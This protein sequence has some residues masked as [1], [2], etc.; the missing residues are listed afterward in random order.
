M[1]LSELDTTS[2]TMGSGERKKLRPFLSGP[3]QAGNLA[4]YRRAASTK[5]AHSLTGLTLQPVMKKATVEDN[6]DAVLYLAAA[7][8]VSGEILHADAAAPTRRWKPQD[9]LILSALKHLASCQ[10]EGS[11]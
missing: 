11:R 9:N 1:S 8:H 6:V 7:G 2:L 4:E 10:I 3:P 5:Y